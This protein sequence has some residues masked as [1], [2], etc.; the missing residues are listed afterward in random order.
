MP[1]TTSLFLPA[2]AARCPGLTANTVLFEHLCALHYTL[3]RLPCKRCGMDKSILTQ[4][5][6]HFRLRTE[7]ERR[8][9]CFLVRGEHLRPPR[10]IDLADSVGCC[11]C[12][13]KYG[14]G[15]TRTHRLVH[16]HAAGDELP[17]LAGQVHHS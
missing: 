9:F 6:F 5:P 4:K 7:A 17:R 13:M 8:D 16:V 3:T 1:V 15:S 2:S 11:V 12:G 14:K 10:L